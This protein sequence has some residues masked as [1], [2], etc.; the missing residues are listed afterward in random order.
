MSLEIFL[1]PEVRSPERR[2]GN[3]PASETLAL[4]QPGATVAGGQREAVLTADDPREAGGPSQLDAGLGDD[5]LGLDGHHAATGRV[6]AAQRDRAADG[7]L[8][9]RLAKQR[10]P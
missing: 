10:V 3:Q 5:D 8:P 2:A 6:D 4:D 9:G 1:A 7:D